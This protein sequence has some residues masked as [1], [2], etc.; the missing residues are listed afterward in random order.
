MKKPNG[1]IEQMNNLKE[2]HLAKKRVVARE[3]KVMGLDAMND[4]RE[5][6]AV[7]KNVPRGT[8]DI[9]ALRAEVKEKQKKFRRP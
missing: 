5:R 6:N 2:N 3:V 8:P 9:P 1:F 7:R 4:L